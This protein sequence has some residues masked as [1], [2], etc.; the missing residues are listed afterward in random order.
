MLFPGSKVFTATKSYLFWYKGFI[1]K[2]LGVAWKYCLRNFKNSETDC[3]I[4]QN[5][6]YSLFQLQ[7][8]DKKR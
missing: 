1:N 3:T 8:L 2:S 4:S 5:K 7:Q 6:I